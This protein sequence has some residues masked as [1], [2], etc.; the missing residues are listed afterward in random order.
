MLRKALP[1][2]YW[3]GKTN[4][5]TRKRARR[6]FMMEAVD[7]QLL[8]LVR[9]EKRRNNPFLIR[10]L[11]YARLDDHDDADQPW[12]LKARSTRLALYPTFWQLHRV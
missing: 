2:F 5:E 1:T 3:S 4:A 6:D 8:E 10:N 7:A 12:A 11:S 9:L